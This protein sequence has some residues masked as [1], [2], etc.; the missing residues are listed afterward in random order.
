MTSASLGSK[1]LIKAA[2]E[3]AAN[4]H[5]RIEDLHSRDNKLPQLYGIHRSEQSIRI[6]PWYRAQS[7]KNNEWK[8]FCLNDLLHGKPLRFALSPGLYTTLE[9]QSENYEC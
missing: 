5:K 1:H 4:K 8:S 9:Q 2:S 6:D 7:D 3:D